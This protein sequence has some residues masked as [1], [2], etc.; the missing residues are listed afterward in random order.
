M[1][2][3][4]LV[5]DASVAVKWL[6]PEVGREEALHLQEHYQNETIDLIAP[7]LLVSEIANV[8][9]KRERRGDLTA[10]AAQY[11]FQQFLLDCP[12]LVESA[13][14]TRSALGLA[15]AHK[16]TVYDCLYLAWALARQCDLI[17][18]DERFFRAMSTVFPCV[19]L[20]QALY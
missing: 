15:L 3:P 13:A 10:Q 12:V 9:W 16:R 19:K 14:V 7:Y 6:L 5:V 4:T 11:C 2:R 8:L 20:L 18:A 1:Q 17:T